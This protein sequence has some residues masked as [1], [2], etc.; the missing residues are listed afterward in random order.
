[1]LQSNLMPASNLK[2]ASHNAPPPPPE[3][4]AS[5]NIPVKLPSFGSLNTPSAEYANFGWALGDQ[6][7]RSGPLSPGMLNAPSYGPNSMFDPSSIRTGLTPG[8]P[9]AGVLAQYTPHSPATQ[10]LFAMMTNQTPGLPSLPKM[11]NHQERAGQNREGVHHHRNQSSG[12]GGGLAGDHRGR[13]HSPG[14]SSRSPTQSAI[15]QQHPSNNIY[16]QALPHPLPPQQSYANSSPTSISQPF[17]GHA[18]RASDFLHQVQPRP[19]P[20]QA[21]NGS[22]HGNGLAPTTM[23]GKGNPSHLGPPEASHQNPLY[24][25]SQAHAHLADVPNQDA[26]GTDDAVLAAAAGLSGLSTPRP[27][28]V[29]GPAPT[30]IPTIA[31]THLNVST[32]TNLSLPNSVP[33]NPL[34]GSSIPTAQQH[35]NGRGRRAAPTSTT[36]TIA[37]RNKRKNTFQAEHRPETKK[38]KRAPKRRATTT[39]AQPIVD[40]DTPEE[41]SDPDDEDMM[42]MI[43]DEDVKSNSGSMRSGRSGSAAG[44]GGGMKM[45]DG[46]MKNLANK[47]GRGPKHI[48]ETEDEKRKNFLE[49]NRQGMW[50]LVA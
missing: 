26:Q 25:L 40:E 7:L 49:R 39:N 34:K 13:S 1:M 41:Y 6:S 47:S 8:G 42:N 35:H 20:P 2:P 14:T 17:Q 24:L 19:L 21:L 33:A 36:A 45:E 11:E 10:A 12:S 29:G 18:R 38:A 22:A 27:S 31:P 28:Y 43:D 16:S 30:G 32:S 46:D 48:F 5:T 23:A 4:A 50:I 15:N 9:L 37:P 44:A 3:S